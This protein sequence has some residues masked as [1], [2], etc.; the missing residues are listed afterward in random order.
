MVDDHLILFLGKLDISLSKMGRKYKTEEERI[1]A[2]KESSKQYYQRNKEKRIEYSTEYRKGHKEKIA[3]KDA[4]YRSTK[5]G[6]AVYRLYNYKLEDM[7]YNRGE[8]TLTRDWI[9]DNIFSGQSCVYCGESDWTKLGCDR[10]DNS[11]PHTP[12]NVVPCCVRCNKKKA[13]FSYEKFMRMIGK[14]G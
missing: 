5:R 8:C 4:K 14:T 11:K 7:K 2:R 12:E 1:T 9:V 13:R 10:I 3:E 6:K